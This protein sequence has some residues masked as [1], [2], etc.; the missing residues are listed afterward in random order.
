MDEGA[1]VG[2]RRQ[3]GW[4]GVRLCN[5]PHRA[6]SLP[7]DEFKRKVERELTGRETEPS[8]I[9]ISSCTRARF[10]SVFERSYLAGNFS[11]RRV[12]PS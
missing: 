10:Q 2:E 4:A 5:W 8:E 1:G 11:V 9:V 12:D 7:K 6:R 3:E